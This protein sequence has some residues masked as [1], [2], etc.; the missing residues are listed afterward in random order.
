MSTGTQFVGVPKRHCGFIFIVKHAKHFI[1][2]HGVTTRMALVISK[3]AE[4]SWLGL[5]TQLILVSHFPVRRL[6]AALSCGFVAED[7][8]FM[9]SLCVIRDAIKRDPRVLE[10][11][12]FYKNLQQNRL[13]LWL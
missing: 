4:I 10:L 12:P 6:Y 1:S 2:V 7:V 5:T 13:G 8:L 3:L 9:Y 11:Y